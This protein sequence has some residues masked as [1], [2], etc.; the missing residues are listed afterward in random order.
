MRSGSNSSLRQKPK[1]HN[2]RYGA[3]TPIQMR[4]IRIPSDS[5]RDDDD[6]EM[7]RRATQDAGMNAREQPPLSQC[8]LLGTELLDVRFYFII[9]ACCSLLLAGCDGSGPP[10]HFSVPDGFRGVFKISVD[11]KN[12][13]QPVKSNG[14][15]MIV[16]PT[17]AHLTLSDDLFFRRWHTETASYYSGKPVEDEPMSTNAIRLRGLFTDTERNSW[18]LIGTRREQDIAHRARVWELPLGRPLTDVALPEN[19]AGR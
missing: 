3:R 1:L 19:A 7:D 9:L 2:V 12:G 6:L 5:L 15:W 8:N 17:N 11:R 18:W 10:V 14:V 13:V 16:V 4:K